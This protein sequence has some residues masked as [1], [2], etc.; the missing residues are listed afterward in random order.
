MD[1]ADMVNSNVEKFG[2]PV[3]YTPPGGDAVSISYAQW[4]EPD[5]IM[6]AD[7][8]GRSN[9]RRAYCTVK[10]DDVAAPTRN[11][12]IVRASTSEEWTVRS[13]KPVRNVAWRLELTR[14]EPTE[15]SHGYRQR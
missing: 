11:A 10:D 7:T 1:W 6:V 2:E 14:K 13:W 4:D 3:T 5:P 15:R 9:E 8:T 12:V